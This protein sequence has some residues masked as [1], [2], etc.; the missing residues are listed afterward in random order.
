MPS[1]SML[2]VWDLGFKKTGN[3]M[4]PLAPF[5]GM[6]RDSTS[7]ENQRKRTRF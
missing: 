4:E 7:T 1:E 6:H 2:R 5:Q 3:E